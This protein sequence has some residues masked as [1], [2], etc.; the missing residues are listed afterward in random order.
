MAGKEV[1]RIILDVVEGSTVPRVCV[2]YKG[3]GDR[4]L[5]DKMNFDDWLIVHWTIMESVRHHL[6]AHVRADYFAEKKDEENQ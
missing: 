4:Y 6:Y 2:E 1:S 5:L 3:S